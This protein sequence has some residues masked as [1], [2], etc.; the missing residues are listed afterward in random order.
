MRTRT[1]IA[2]VLG[3]WLTVGIAATAL[4]GDDDTE[5]D[6]FALSR[7]TVLLASLT[8]FGA[9]DELLAYVQEHALEQVGPYGLGGGGFGPVLETMAVD[10]AETAAFGAADGAADGAARASAESVPA[11]GEDF[12]GTNVQEAGVDEPD[13]VKTD[14]RILYTAVGEEIR[15]VDVSGDRP[16]EV[17]SLRLEGEPWGRELLL[18]GDRLLVLGT[19]HDAGR[20]GLPRPVEDGEAGD[21]DA[22]VAGDGEMSFG[23]L[24]LGTAAATL[25]VV[26]VGDPAA[27][28]VVETLRLDGSYLSARLVDG[29][30]RVVIRSEPNALPFVFPEGGGIRAEETAEERNREVI[31]ASTAED[32]LPYFVHTDAAGTRTEGTLLDCASVHRPGAFSGL[33]TVTVLSIDP[34]RDLRADA[35]TA[36]LA[37]GDTIAASPDRLYVATTRWVDSGAAVT[38]DASRIAPVAPSGSQTT[39]IHAFDITAPAADYIGSGSVP[40]FLLNQFALSEHAGHLRVATT[41]GTPAWEGAEPQSSRVT[42]LAERAGELAEV[43]AVADL[44]PDERIYAVR[45]LGDI[46]YVVTFRETDPLYTIDLRDP[47]APRVLGELKIPGYSAYLHPIGDDLVLGI[48]Q[49]ADAQGMRLG[50]QLSLFDI[51]DLASPQRLATLPLGGAGSSTDVEH[52][53]RAFLHWAATGLGVVPVQEWSYDEPSQTEGFHAE[54]VGFTA[55]RDGLRELGRVS[56]LAPPAMPEAGVSPELAHRAAIRRSVVVGDRLLTISE[57]GVLASDLHTLAPSGFAPFGS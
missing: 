54:A 46:G 47:T 51:A 28:E 26:D 41:E 21:G 50:A 37:G 11:A 40:G 56:H 7:P 13:L 52:D 5:D 36:V 15:A 49:D 18:E 48:G 24:P 55:S 14:G 39:E 32:W 25:T 35:A 9:C 42:V 27:M 1:A 12:S 10:D 16:S 23:V 53:H 3:L 6:S 34:S 38:P 2:A 22:A 33:G 4:P 31:R 20:P 30:A 8:P 29:V 17:G 43:G 57:Q 45:F 19:T 44:G